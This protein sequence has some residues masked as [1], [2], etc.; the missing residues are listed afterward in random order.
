MNLRKASILVMILFLIALAAGLTAGCGGDT[1]TTTAAGGGTATTGGAAPSGDP[2]VLGAIVSATG[3]NAALGIQEVN[4]LK[5]ME[6]NLNAAG[7]VLGRPVKIVV[8][9][10]KSDAKEA[11]TAANK[12]IDQDKAVALIAATG[13]ASTVAVKAIT[14][15][16][17]LPQMAMVA[18]SVVT[19][20]PPIDWLWR[21]AQKNSVVA[22]LA[23]KYISET[24]QVKKIAVL[25]DENA[26]GADGQKAIAALAAEY[27]LEI[28]ATESYK[29]DETD[30]T[31]QLTKIKGA[32]PEV[33]VVW[34]TNPG[35]AI[36]AKNLKQ[37]AMDI[38]YVGSHG[39]ANAKFIELA[40]DAAEGVVFPAGALLMP[41]SIT[42]AA[43]KKV[44]DDFIAA[45]KAAYN[46]ESPNPYAGYAFEAVNL[47]V[48]AITKAG[49][50]DAKAIQ[51]ALNGTQG[52]VMPD[53]TFNYSATDHDGL[54]ADDMIMVRI[55][56]GTWELAK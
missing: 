25:H 5:M 49:S 47:L 53:G 9:D 16:K 52:F 24:L 12:L 1:T 13:S 30:L 35:P 29:T 14:A 44:T 33:L 10:D 55:K 15:Q 18:A 31:A 41:S 19:D 42:D 2:I 39:I 22:K 11:V 26:F 23:L 48:N 20:E 40:G 36:A 28:V 45:Y 38:P 43:R 54:S 17:G 51:T 6:T 27:G 50:T 46:G 34:G 56:G 32:N 21:T 3:P 4:V 8:E 7:G 37:L